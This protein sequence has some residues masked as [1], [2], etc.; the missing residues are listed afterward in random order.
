[1]SRITVDILSPI[2]IHVLDANDDLHDL[3]T[4][5][6]LLVARAETD[7]LHIA[8]QIIASRVPPLDAA[9]DVFDYSTTYG[10]AGESEAPELRRTPLPSHPLL[11]TEF[12]RPSEP[13]TNRRCA[14]GRRPV[15][16]YAYLTGLSIGV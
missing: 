12:I 13:R 6:A 1:M 4:E 16:R 3:L 11:V 10:H 15:E 5:G 8:A 14:V 9:T 2:P 7:G